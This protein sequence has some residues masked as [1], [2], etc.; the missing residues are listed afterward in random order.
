VNR[1]WRLIVFLV[2]AALFGLLVWH[3]GPEKLAADLHRAKW[4]VLPVAALWIPIN[5]LYGTSWWLTMAGPAERPPWWRAVV[6]STSSFAMN[7]VTPF[8][9]AGGEVYRTTAAAPWIGG[10]RATSSTVT[11]YIVHALSNI[12]SWI[13]SGVLLL[14]FFT[15]PPA[16]IA[17]I[18]LVIVVLS[19]VVYLALSQH[20]RGIVAPLLNLLRRTPLLGRLARPL[21]RHRAKIE[22]LDALITGFH[23][24]HPRAFWG[25]IAVDCV[26]RILSAGEYWFAAR[27]LG[28]PIDPMQAFVIGAFM[29]FGINMIFFVPLEAGVKEGSLYLAFHTLGFAPALGV[30]AAIVQRLREFTWI[31]IGLLLIWVTGDKPA[32]RTEPADGP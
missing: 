27:G 8:F 12:G 30:F 1:T 13:L 10:R 32:T 18:L 6:I 19:A 11:F 21:E 22:E 14:I 7:L 31:A 16:F 24:D 15:P 23:R 9:Q 4:V 3:V 2:G 29:T 25:A 20:Q 17:P 5:I 28:V 26:G